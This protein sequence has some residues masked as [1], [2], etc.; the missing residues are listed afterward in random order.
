[1]HAA[2]PVRIPEARDVIRAANAIWSENRDEYGLVDLD[3]Y[4]KNC[5]KLPSVDLPIRAKRVLLNVFM[6]SGESCD[7]AKE[8]TYSEWMKVYGCGH[9]TAT[10]LVKFFSSFPA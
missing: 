2:I 6:A 5:G 9:V 7:Y 8:F 10:Q 3:F 4:V 1:M